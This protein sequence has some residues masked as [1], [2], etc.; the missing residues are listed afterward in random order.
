MQVGATGQMD[1][2]QMRKM[3]GTGGGQGKGGNNGM[4]DIMQSL[5]TEDRAALQEQMSTLS[6]ED[7]RDMIDQMKQV[8]SSSM[9]SE[10]YVDTLLSLFD[11]SSTEDT[12]TD[13]N[14]TYT[15]YA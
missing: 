15:V 7:R 1:Q 2:I 14:S 10:D 8:D 12:V 13:E 6:T 11:T 4:K 5:S 3:D 9:S